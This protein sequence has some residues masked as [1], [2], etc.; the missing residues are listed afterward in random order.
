MH[1][2][3]IESIELELTLLARRITSFSSNKKLGDL[4]RSAY[5]LLGHIASIGT[6]GIKTLAEQLHLDISTVSRQTAALEQ[7]GYVRKSPDPQDRRAYLFH[8]SELGNEALVTYKQRRLS[9]ISDRLKDWNEEELERFGE[10]LRK[11]NESLCN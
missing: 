1:E 5:L 9:R 11:F 10:L 8:N 4:D 6:V 3:S 2:S 7:K